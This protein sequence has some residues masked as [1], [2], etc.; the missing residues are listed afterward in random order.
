VTGVPSARLGEVLPQRPRTCAV[1]RSLQ[2]DELERSL[3]S[4]CPGDHLLAR[5][6]QK[7]AMATN[8]ESVTGFRPKTDA[9]NGQKIST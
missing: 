2:L 4:D 7:G 6:K 1:H 3:P 9:K 8:S 5:N